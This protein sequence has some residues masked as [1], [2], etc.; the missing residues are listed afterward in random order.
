MS[1]EIVTQ[2]IDGLP[3][4]TSEPFD[5]SFLKEYGRVFKVFDNQDSGCICYGVSDGEHRYFIKFAGVKTMRHHQHSH[6]P[7]AVDRIK[8]AVPKYIDMAHPLLIRLIEAKEVGGGYIS[9]FD[10]FDGESFSVEIPQLHEKYSALPKDKKVSIYERILQFHEYAAKCG[11]V[12]VDFNDYSTLYNFDTG[13]VKICDIDFYAK[14][15]Y[16]NG[17]GK[18]LG[19]WM[20][21]SPEEQRI[22]GVLDEATNVYR[23]GATAF[24]LFSNY[25]RS[26][27]AWQLSPESY[28]VVTKAVSDAKSDRQQ[29]ITQLI[30]EWEKFLQIRH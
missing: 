17:L 20:L 25:D 2:Y 13:E 9:V 8:A 10:W 14:Q 15:P 29:S 18:S 6:I 26:P 3:C 5:F 27:E 23:M 1:N 4:R 24:M 11:Y 28:T 12:A 7:D 22:A 16:I 19:D 21:M 30:E